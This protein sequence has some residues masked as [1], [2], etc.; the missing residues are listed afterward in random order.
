[1][2]SCALKRMSDL[3]ASAL[4][5]TVLQ[6]TGLPIR[7]DPDLDR[8]EW[9]WNDTPYANRGWCVLESSLSHEAVGRST[10]HPEMKSAMDRLGR[11]KVYEV[12]TEKEPEVRQLE[13]V[14]GAHEIAK[15]IRRSK[16]TGKQDRDQ[17]CDMFTDYQKRIADAGL[18]IF[19]KK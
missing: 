3:Y 14:Q 7:E 5:T 2:F 11:A 9:Q 8:E 13:K 18:F 1:M 6:S 12:F 4:G 10:R 17:V 19:G 15:I 16:F